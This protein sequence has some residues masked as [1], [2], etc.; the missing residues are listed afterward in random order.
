MVPPAWARC[1]KSAKLPPFIM[2]HGRPA[3]DSGFL[4][5]SMRSSC[6][7][8]AIWNLLKSFVWTWHAHSGGREKK[9]WEGHGPCTVSVR[10]GVGKGVH[11]MIGE[12]R[13]VRWEWSGRGRATPRAGTSTSLTFE[14][15][16]APPVVL[17]RA[18]F[19][20]PMSKL[21]KLQTMLSH[22]L[23][24]GFVINRLGFGIG[25]V[26]IRTVTGGVSRNCAPPT[27]T[28]GWGAAMVKAVLAYTRASIFQIVFN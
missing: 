8:I 3:T 2:G 10:V 20:G 18:F 28:L 16:P 15:G 24:G 23:G 4:D 21:A 19:F 26:L 27:Q 6:S 11:T 14:T 7:R 9:G 5:L 25:L 22:V 13:A 12:R 17:M 1:A